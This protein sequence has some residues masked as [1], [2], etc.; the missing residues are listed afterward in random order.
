MLLVFEPS[1]ELAEY[2]RHEGEEFAIVLKGHVQFVSDIYEPVLLGEMDGIYIDSRMGHAY[3][4]A[5]KGESVILNV[6]TVPH[7]FTPAD[8]L[9]TN[10]D[11]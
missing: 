10:S 9:L 2:G 8:G 4:N 6:S 5:G 3:L 11:D 7:Q 1:A